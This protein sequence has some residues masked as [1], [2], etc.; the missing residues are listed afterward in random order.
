M[1]WRVWQSSKATLQEIETHWSLTD[2]WT[3]NHML[4]LE[5]DIQ[6]ENYNNYL[7]AK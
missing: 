1:I 3:A 4:D 5:M 6:M 2:L 7:E